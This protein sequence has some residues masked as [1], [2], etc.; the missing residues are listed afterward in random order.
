MRPDLRLDEDLE[1]TGLA[2]W[3]V[4][5]QIEHE[6]G[7]TFPD[8]VVEGWRTLSDVLRDTADAS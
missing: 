4:V 1:L 5:S 8:R 3:S 2:L 6:L 7:I